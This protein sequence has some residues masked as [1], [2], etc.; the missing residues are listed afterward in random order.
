M[1]TWSLLQLFNS[2]MWYKSS[3]VQDISQWAWLHP[4][5]TLLTKT[6]G[7][8]LTYSLYLANFCFT[9][10]KRNETWSPPLNF[11]PS[12]F[13]GF[14]GG[15]V[16][17]ESACQ[18]RKCRRCGFYPWVRKIPWR[19]AWQ[20]TPVFLPGKFH[21]QR[22]LAGYSPWGCKELDMTEHLSTSSFSWWY[23]LAAKN[24]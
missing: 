20:L 4:N 11:S 15:A 1:A 18:C 23:F 12:S 13:R 6:H 9:K 8:D 7:L 21:E 22:S 24:R 3:H 14:V 5:K 2:A 17:K 10:A 19:R 16:R